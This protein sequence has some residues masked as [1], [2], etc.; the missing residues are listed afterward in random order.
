MDFQ[1]SDFFSQ[2]VSVQKYNLCDLEGGREGGREGEGGVSESMNEREC[3]IMA[4]SLFGTKILIFEQKPY[5]KN[6]F[7]RFYACH[8]ARKTGENCYFCIS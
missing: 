1:K 5:P 8:S 4:L 6:Y 2:N 3:A 7:T